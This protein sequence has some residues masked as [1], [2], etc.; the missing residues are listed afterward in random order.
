MPFLTVPSTLSVLHRRVVERFAGNS[1]RLLSLS[2]VRQT[3]TRKHGVADDSSLSNDSHLFVDSLDESSLEEIRSFLKDNGEDIQEEQQ[4]QHQ[5][6]DGLAPRDLDQRRIRRPNRFGYIFGNIYRSNYYNQFLHPSV[7]ERT[8][9]QSKDKDS[10]FRSSFRLPLHIIDNLARMFIERDWSQPTKRINTYTQ[11]FDRTQLLI[12]C[13]LEHLG[14]RRPFRQF[15]I[16]TELSPEEHRRFFRVFI[17]EI[18]NTKDEWIHYPKTLEKLSEVMKDYQEFYLPGCGGSI[19][20][21]HLKWSCC[22]AGDF[23][24]ACGKEKFP[25][26]A[27]ECVSDSRH[28]ILGVSPVQFGARNDKHI[29]RIDPTVALIH[30]DWYRHV[31]WYYFNLLGEVKSSRGIYLICDNGYHR[32]PTLICPFKGES[33]ASRNG[34]F[35]TNLESVRKDVECTFGILKKRWQILE[36][37]IHYREIETL[38]EVFLTCCVLHNMMADDAESRDNQIRVGRGRPLGADAIYIWQPPEDGSVR[39]SMNVS[40][41]NR[42]HEAQWSERRSNLVDHLEYCRRR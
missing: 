9:I 19:D 39:R 5:Q 8:Y 31:E 38:E 10:I 37:G 18:S 12:M 33:V 36:Y 34:F 21:V 28:R 22:P 24:R 13:S 40:T 25:T 42:R 27:F 41:T 23:N 32:W 26:V 7:R 14:S 1:A 20:V 11:V 4:R 2:R 3:I 30:E 16:E 29:V 35:S 17:K 6:R 15:K